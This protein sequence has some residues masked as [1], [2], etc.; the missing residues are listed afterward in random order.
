MTTGFPE[1]SFTHFF[2]CTFFVSTLKH[3]KRFKT[4]DSLLLRTITAHTV[5]DVA[6]GMGILHWR[7]CDFMWPMGDFSSAD[8]SLLLLPSPLF[9]SSSFYLPSLAGDGRTTVWRQFLFFFSISKLPMWGRGYNYGIGLCHS[10]C[11]R[12]TQAGT[13]TPSHALFPQPQPT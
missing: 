13:D 10:F 9:F 11:G 3:N 7:G 8:C 4:I 5:G 12:Q 6:D 1:L 2:K